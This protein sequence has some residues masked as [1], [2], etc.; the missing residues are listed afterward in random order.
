MTIQRKVIPLWRTRQP[1]RRAGIATPGACTRR[2]DISDI[3]TPSHDCG[4]RA[5]Q[6]AGDRRSRCDR[7]RRAASRCL[8]DS[9]PRWARST[10]HR[11]IAGGVSCHLP[12]RISR[13]SLGAS[14]LHLPDHSSS[15]VRWS[16]S[17]ILG[18]PGRAVHGLRPLA[19]RCVNLRAKRWRRAPLAL[20]R[21]TRTPVFAVRGRLRQTA[22]QTPQLPKV[23]ISAILITAANG[24]QRRVGPRTLV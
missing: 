7:N 20:P 3:M 21:G 1:P 6:I 17:N 9:S 24:G 13:V 2:L 18:A 14:C 4:M 8:A 23:L 22:R 16:W 19:R 12:R 15:S 5:R 10:A 11:T